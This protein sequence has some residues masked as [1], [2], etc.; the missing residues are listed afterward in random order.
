M[1]ERSSRPHASRRRA[2]AAVRQQVVRLRREHRIGPV[3]LAARCG[4]AASAAHRILVW[5]HLPALAA[6]DRA[7]GEPVRRYERSRP[8]KL[9]HLDV[10]KLGRIPDG[11][12]HKVVGRAQG[13]ATGPALDTPPARSSGAWPSSEASAARPPTAR[14]VPAGY[15]PCPQHSVKARPAAAEH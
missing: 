5:H 7:T 2:S 6:C 9:V 8:G 1:Q 15:R 11:G 4:V 12:G 14:Q 10:K 13:A 3:K